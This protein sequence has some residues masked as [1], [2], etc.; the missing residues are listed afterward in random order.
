M[1]LFNWFKETPSQLGDF[2]VQKY[3]LTLKTVGEFDD[4]GM[5]W[6]SYEYVATPIGGGESFIV[7]DTDITV[8]VRSYLNM[9]KDSSVIVMKLPTVPDSKYNVV[10]PSYSDSDSIYKELAQSHYNSYPNAV[11]A[12]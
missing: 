1:K 12:V 9:N 5:P 10:P 6:C 11:R 7:P 4:T 2:D 8:Q 3:T